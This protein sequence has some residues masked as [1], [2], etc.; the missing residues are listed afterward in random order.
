MRPHR[1]RGQTGAA[2]S[3]AL[4]LACPLAGATLGEPGWATPAAD[5]GRATGARRF[6]E[7]TS[8]RLQAQVTTQADGST[9]KEFLTPGGIVFAVSWSTRL[10]PRLDVLLG[11]HAPGYAEAARAAASAPGVHHAATLVAGDLV[12]HE[13]S[14][15]NT[16]VGVAWLRSLVPEGVRVDEL[17]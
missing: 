6:V 15:L 11:A 10:K 12:V 3:L 7:T 14:H 16:H 1:S 8:M 17:R 4:G 13:T 9:I 2:L 5:P